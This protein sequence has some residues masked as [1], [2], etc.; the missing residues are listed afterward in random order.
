MLYLRRDRIK[1]VWPLMAAPESMDDNIRKFEEIGTHSAGMHNALSEAVQFQRAIGVE[2]KSTRL[3]QLHRVWTDQLR[4]IEHVSFQ[5]DLS[6]E[7][8]QC[9]IR[10]VHIKDVDHGKLSEWL[11][12]KH[13]IFTVAIGHDQFTGLRV[14][15][16]VYTT[17]A[18]MERFAQA[19]K[20]VAVDPS[21]VK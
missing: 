7:E 9:G 11:L 15:P 13:H 5:T 18:E 14:T 12:N 1:E 3:R 17:L 10:L 4:D 21:V 2:R 20:S 8:N 16:N 6:S 19:M